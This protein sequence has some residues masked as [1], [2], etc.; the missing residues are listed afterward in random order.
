L[1][2]PNYLSLASLLVDFKQDMELA[3]G[4]QILSYGILSA[5]GVAVGLD[6]L[7]ARQ[8][9]SRVMISWRGEREE[10]R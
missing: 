4:I 7:K 3:T 6:F 1:N 10:V 5:A 9:L 2:L 8:Q